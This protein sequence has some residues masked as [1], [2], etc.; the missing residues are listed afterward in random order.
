MADR[1]KEAILTILLQKSGVDAES[2]QQRAA[3]LLGT[4]PRQVISDQF[5]HA[6]I[7]AAGVHIDSWGAGPFKITVGDET[8]EF[9]D[10][11]RFGPVHCEDGEPSGYQFIEKSPFWPAWEAWKSQG[12]RVA[13]DGVTCIW[14]AA[15]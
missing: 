12:R 3:A 7:S 2:S 11:D 6:T 5:G 13:A 8:F 4:N 14:D 9:E 15:E 1:N 10:S